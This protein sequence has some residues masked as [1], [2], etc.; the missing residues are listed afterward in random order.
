MENC[1]VNLIV[2]ARQW[3]KGFEYSDFW[4]PEFSSFLVFDSYIIPAKNTIPISLEFLNFNQVGL[5][6]YFLHG[7]LNNTFSI[8]HSS[9]NNSLDLCRG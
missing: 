4:S 9:R 7:D 1:S 2:S 3:N 5:I 6:S 8:G